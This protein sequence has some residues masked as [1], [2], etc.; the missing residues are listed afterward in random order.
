MIKIRATLVFT[1]LM[2]IGSASIFFSS[3][4]NNSTDGM[5]I[6]TRAAGE[7]K[8]SYNL[9][10]SSAYSIQAQIVSIDP[11]KP[12][13]TLKILSKEFYSAKSP[14][15]S[16]DGNFMLFSGKLKQNDEWQIWEMNLGNNKSRLITKTGGN[17]AFPD[18]LPGDR[19]VFSK[20]APKDSLKAGNSIFTCKLDGSSLQ[21]ITFN[22]EDY[23]AINVMKDGRVLTMGNQVYPEKGQR[24]LMVLR[25]DGTKLELFYKSDED[26]VMNSTARETNGKLLFIENQKTGEKGNLIS[27]SYNRPLHSRINLSSGL[28]GDFLSVCPQPSGKLLVSYR[29]SASERYSL[30]EFDPENKNIGKAIYSDNGFDVLEAVVAGKH[31]RPKKLPSEVDMGVKTGLI[32]CQNV[33]VLCA[34]PQTAANINSSA[35]QVVGIDSVIGRVDAAADG[36]FYLKV[37]ADKPFRIQTIDKDGHIQPNICGWISLRPNERRGCVGCHEDPEFVPG[38]R[39]PLSVKK[40]P[41][42]IPMH[43]NKVVE[44]KVSLE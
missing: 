7:Q 41:V 18:Y 42:N 32:L 10:D 17:C 31:E 43:I 12:E 9:G 13:S 20:Y 34:Q 23:L 35:I 44:K 25:P 16:Y 19:M 2:A 38:N 30:Y 5:I 33:N 14:A 39:V 22:P 4:K 28:E 26:F 11:Q 15:I 24:M 8:K 21:R 37:I 40:S 27:I 29:K 1:V 3:C 36:S 6:I